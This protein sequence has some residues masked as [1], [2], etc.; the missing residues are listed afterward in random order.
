MILLCRTRPVAALLAVWSIAVLAVACTSGQQAVRPVG[1]V[2]T[3][4]APLADPG[5][6]EEAPPTV[7]M[8]PGFVPAD[9]RGVPLLKFPDY[10]ID[11][12]PIPVIGG[13]AN[14][15]GVVTGPDGAPV[16]GAIVRLERF[17]GRQGGF[18]DIQANDQ[19][20]YDISGV[21]G[22]HY[23]VRAWVKPH[24]ATVEA[25]T[26]FLA[27]DGSVQVD[28]QLELHDQPKLSA[29]ITVPEWQM[30]V[31][32]FLVGLFV[33][34]EV[35]D[36]GIVQGKP[37][38]DVP[39]SLLTPPGIRLESPNPVLTGPDGVAIWVIMCTSPAEQTMTVFGPNGLMYAYT[40]PPC[41][42]GVVP[43]PT[44]TPPVGAPTTTV[45]PVPELPVGGTF[46]VPYTGPVPAGVYVAVANSMWCR[47]AY[48]LERGGQ[49]VPVQTNGGVLAPNSSA[50]NFRSLTGSPPCTFRRIR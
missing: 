3:T 19:G 4:I 43:P 23:R 2:T 36:D 13:E 24:L 1:T 12:P 50:R 29:A 18:I 17:A 42:P 49:W 44:T 37:I 33:Q 8:P 46:T 39:L 47:T 26:A 6:V 27:S 41:A 16:G 10:N 31:P 14:I 7:P 38:P 30:G 34:E 32:T 21:L 28:V 20:F 9:T 11:L 35:D 48:E 25:Q 15:H 45:P 22:G 40:T 5:E